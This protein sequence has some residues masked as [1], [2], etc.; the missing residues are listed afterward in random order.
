MHV[1]VFLYI[2]VKIGQQKNKSGSSKPS[3]C[4]PVDR[5]RQEEEGTKET[6]EA[7]FQSAALVFHMAMQIMQSWT[8]ERGRKVTKSSL[9]TSSRHPKGRPGRSI[10]SRR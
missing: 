7:T 6:T 5:A 10:K 9:N 3:I 4:T 1:V 2:S 8:D